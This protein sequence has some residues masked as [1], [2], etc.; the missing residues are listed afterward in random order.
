MSVD[1]EGGRERNA[2]NFYVPKISAERFLEC[3][4]L[5]LIAKYFR[6][7][8]NACQKPVRLVGRRFNIDGVKKH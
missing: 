1:C 7:C 6:N 5:K 3:C 8:Q 4:Q 2:L